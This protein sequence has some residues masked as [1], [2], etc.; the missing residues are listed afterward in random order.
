MP[1]LPQAQSKYQLN[2]FDQPSCVSDTKNDLTCPCLSNWC[3]FSS[4][5]R[6][7]REQEGFTL[8]LNRRA[9]ESVVTWENWTRWELTKLSCIC[10]T[11]SL[12]TLTFCL[13]SSERATEEGREK[14][15]RF[16]DDHLSRTK[17]DRR[18]KL[19]NKKPKKAVNSFMEDPFPSENLAK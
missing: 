7:T 19:L 4:R 1:M 9:A 10:F 8:S 3:L 15:Q 16:V 6:I 12:L 2:S 17:K 13:I 11:L 14:T 5:E 18:A